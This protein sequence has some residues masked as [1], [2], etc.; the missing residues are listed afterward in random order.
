M[1]CMLCTIAR[2]RRIASFAACT[3]F[4]AIVWLGLLPLVARQPP[5]RRHIERLDDRGIDPSA[6]FYTEVYEAGDLPP[7]R[8]R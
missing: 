5:V 7:A 2:T 3:L 6:M 4:V 1:I 8:Y